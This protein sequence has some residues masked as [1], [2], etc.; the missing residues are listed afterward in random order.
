[1]WKVVVFHISRQARS[2]KQHF[3]GGSSFH[4]PPNT[5]RGMVKAVHSS[6]HDVHFNT[7]H[8]LDLTSRLRECHLSSPTHPWGGAPALMFTP[9]LH[10]V[11]SS[12]TAWFLRFS[13]AN[14]AVATRTTPTRYVVLWGRCLASESLCLCIR[15]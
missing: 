4:G 14:A 1:M 15:G 12:Q 2:C 11:I 3:Q 13:D 6:K 10:R 8:I 7:H 5:T 9:S